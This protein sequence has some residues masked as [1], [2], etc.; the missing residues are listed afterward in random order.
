VAGRH[1][2]PDLVVAATLA[3][4]PAVGMWWVYFDRLAERAQH[5]LRDHDDPVLAAADA[6][7]Y[8]HLVIVAGIII[9][10]DGVRLTVHNSATAPMPTA[11]RLALCGGVA[12]YLIGLAAFRLRI[13]GERS[14]AA[15]L[16]AA[17][18]MALFA[19]GGSLP[20]W[21]IPAGISILL[22]VLCAFE[23]LGAE[24][25]EDES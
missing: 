4:L 6:Y 3:L 15:I 13:A 18:L 1:L 21:S 19:L 11:G 10:A 23:S 2:T 9:F 17:A 14:L 7:S 22:G 8:L 20:A 16:V 25:S 24:P 5:R 12:V